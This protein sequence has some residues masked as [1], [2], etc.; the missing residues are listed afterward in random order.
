MKLEEYQE[1]KQAERNNCL[2]NPILAEKD[3]VFSKLLK[4]SII[5]NMLNVLRFEGSVDYSEEYVLSRNVLK[6]TC[7]LQGNGTVDKPYCL[8]TPF[9]EGGFVDVLYFMA[10]NQIPKYIENNSCHRNCYRFASRQVDNCEAI[11]GIYKLGE[12]AQLHSVIGVNGVILDFNY[13]IAMTE[14]LYC[15]LFN[16]EIINRVDNQKIKQ[17]ADFIYK[18]I[19]C[20]GTEITYAEVLACYDEVLDLLKKLAN[21]HSV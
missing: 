9:G 11:T 1:L 3:S 17:N 20:L 6:S 14:D 21:N 8:H 7:A 15:A 2:R 5:G 19:K 16:F 10:N 4:R 18:N 13:K 12:N